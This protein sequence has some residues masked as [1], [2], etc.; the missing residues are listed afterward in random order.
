MQ[1]NQDKMQKSY[2]PWLYTANFIFSNYMKFDWT[3]LKS[4]KITIKLKF[5]ARKLFYMYM[6]I[7]MLKDVNKVTVHR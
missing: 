1:N 2:G 6:L 3:S 7:D 5:C 4:A